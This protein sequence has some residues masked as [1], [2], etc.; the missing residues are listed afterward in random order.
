MCY[1]KRARTFSPREGRD[2]D[3]ISWIQVIADMFY[4]MFCQLRYAALSGPCPD[5]ALFIGHRGAYRSLQHR[6]DV[7]TAGNRAAGNRQAPVI[8]SVTMA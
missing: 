8:D 4:P 5:Y 3:A 2:Y 1:T 7:D 6:G